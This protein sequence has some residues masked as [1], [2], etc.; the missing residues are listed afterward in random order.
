MDGSDANLAIAVHPDC[1]M[2]FRN[3]VIY[4]LGETPLESSQHRMGSRTRVPKTTNRTPAAAEQRLCDS[5]E[6]YPT[7]VPAPDVTSWHQRL[8]INFFFAQCPTFPRLFWMVVLI[9]MCSYHHLTSFIRDGSLIHCYFYFVSALLTMGFVM[10]R[11]PD[12]LCNIPRK[13][14]VR[15][16]MR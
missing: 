7:R 5:D 2:R 16:G 12:E 9:G 3:E 15:C 1:M 13:G 14:I 8:L 4:L 10:R 11:A 6:S